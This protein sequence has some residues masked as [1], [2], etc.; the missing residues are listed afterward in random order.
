[1]RREFKMT[2]EQLDHLIEASQPVR[3]M[4]IGGVAPRSPR[5]RAHGAWRDLGQ[6]MGFDWQTVRPAPGKGQRYF[7]AEPIGED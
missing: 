3:Y 5:E 1:M 4:I 6:E 7:T 2:Q